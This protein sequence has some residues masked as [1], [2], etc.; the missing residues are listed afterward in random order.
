MAFFQEPLKGIV[1]DRYVEVEDGP[2]ILLSTTERTRKP[3]AENT[4]VGAQRRND[5]REQPIPKSSLFPRAAES[6]LLPRI[7]AVH[8]KPFQD[9]QS[10]LP[11]YRYRLLCESMA[12]ILA[13]RSAAIA[14]DL[15]LA[16]A[17]VP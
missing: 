8:V 2:F 17:M 11:W 9:G 6:D 1:L 15:A 7:C 16:P 13:R 5:P 14:A 4:I 12:Q 10:K 3:S